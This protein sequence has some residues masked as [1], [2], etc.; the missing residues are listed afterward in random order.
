MSYKPRCRINQC[1]HKRVRPY[2]LFWCP[3]IPVP[4]QA[5][6]LS[7]LMYRLPLLIRPCDPQM[8]WD[9]CR[10][11]IRHPVQIYNLVF[12]AD[13]RAFF[14]ESRRALSSWWEAGFLW[15]KS[16]VFWNTTKR[17]PCTM[18]VCSFPNVTTHFSYPYRSTGKLTTALHV[19]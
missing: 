15:H 16:P 19:F 11:G 17:T 6:P 1:R 5:S 7:E 3:V 9:L 18:N 12:R 14:L 4:N 2:T 10:R 13:Q 8:S